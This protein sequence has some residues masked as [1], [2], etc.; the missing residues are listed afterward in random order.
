MC[1]RLL[2]LLP[3][4][5]RLLAESTNHR[6]NGIHIQCEIWTHLIFLRHDSWLLLNDSALFE[7]F[8]TY[9][10]CSL[11]YDRLTFLPY[12]HSI[13]RQ[14]SSIF[15][16]WLINV[17]RL[18]S[19]SETSLLLVCNFQFPLPIRVLWE[20]ICMHSFFTFVLIAFY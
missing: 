6:L 20:H 3:Y 13:S 2:L 8:N 9:S 4:H 16:A 14:I 1:C 10:S 15:K 18:T 5:W 19:F 12:L 7:L 11:F 17:V